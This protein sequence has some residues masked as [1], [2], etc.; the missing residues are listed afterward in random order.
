MG[1]DGAFD[2]FEQLKLVELFLFSQKVW[3]RF[4]NAAAND[5]I[6]LRAL[7]SENGNFLQKPEI[8]G[9]WRPSIDDNS[10]FVHYRSV[11]RRWPRN[12]C[13]WN[14]KQS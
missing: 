7:P 2:R 14:G 10:C 6:G 1:S 3:F 13:G 8:L 9:F 4:V 5:E 11:A 12:G